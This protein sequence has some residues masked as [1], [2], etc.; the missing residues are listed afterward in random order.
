MAHRISRLFSHDRFFHVPQNALE[1]KYSIPSWQTIEILMICEKS[2]LARFS[3]TSLR[4]QKNLGSAQNF[5]SNMNG[6]T[7][8]FRSLSQAVIKKHIRVQSQK[9]CLVTPCSEHPST[10]I[11]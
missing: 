4:V 7:L 8:T 2:A 11:T 5:L 10:V 1:S 3:V 6:I 9:E